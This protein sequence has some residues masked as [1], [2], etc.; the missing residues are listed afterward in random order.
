M[1]ALQTG[2][3]QPRT[4][5][6]GD[7]VGHLVRALFVDHYATGRGRSLPRL[8]DVHPCAAQG[9]RRW[10]GVGV[11]PVDAIVG[12]ASALPDTRRSDFLPA[13]GHEPA[14]WRSRWNRLES[15]ARNLTPLPPIE[16]LEAGDGYWVLDGHNRVA[17][18]RSIG[19]LWIDADVTTI[20]LPSSRELNPTAQRGT[21]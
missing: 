4:D 11:V 13:S 1:E 6:L 21:A 19:Q 17:L 3:Q 8:A 14:D 7:R 20:V 2:T 12:T 16:L 10:R 5:S 15:A 9:S 18:A